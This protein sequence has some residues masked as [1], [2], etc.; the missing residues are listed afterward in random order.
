M[1]PGDLVEFKPG[2]HGIGAPNNYGIYLDRVRRKGEFYVVLWTVKGKLEMRREALTSRRLTARLDGE[3]D[4]ASLASRLQQLLKDLQKGKVREEQEF[5]GE[6]TDRELWRK[7][8][9]TGD[10]CSAETL[11]TLHFGQGA[12]KSQVEAV[13]KALERC[14]PGVGYFRR[15]PGKEERWLPIGVEQYKAAKREVEGFYVLRKKLVKEEQ[16]VEEGWPEPRTAY[17][18]VPPGEAGLTE[19]D[20]GRLGVAQRFMA[21]FV[22]HDRDTG[23]VTLGETGIHTIDGFSLFDFCRWLSA[24]WLGGALAGI[25]STFVEFLVEAGLWTEQEAL[26]AVAQR[27]V[28]QHPD[29]AWDTPEQVER[30]ANR[31][32]EAFPPAWLEPR[33]DLR[34]GHACF[35]IDPPDAKDFD[36]AV[37]VDFHADGSATLWVHIADVSHYVE[38]GALLDAHAR[39][40]ATSVYLPV[41]VLPMLPHRLSDDLC[42]LRA[43][44]DR[45]AM[46]AKLTYDGEGN[47]LREEFGES[48]IRVAENKHYGQ[49]DEAVR[50]G[51]E[52]FA[53]MEAFARRLGAKR[54]GLALETG[55]RKILFGPDGLVDPTLKSAT[56]ATRMIEVFMVAANE[57][58]ARKLTAEG[59]PLPYRC[60]PLPDRAAAERFNAQMRTME[61]PLAIQLPERADDEEGAEPE[62]PSLLE[63]LQKGGKLQLVSGG[64]KLEDEAPGAEPGEAL[65]P[66]LKGLAQ[67]GDEEQERWLQPFRDALAQVAALADEEVRDLV[68]LKLL[69]CMGRAFYTPRNLGHF[70]LGSTCYSHFTSPIRRYPDL[71]THRLLRWLLRGRPGE[72]PHT[73]EDLE[74]LSAHCSEQGSAAEELERGVVDVAMVFASRSEGLGA[75]RRGLVTGI[76]K[77]GVF[78]SFPGGLEGKLFVSDIPGGPYAVDEHDSMLFQGELER[79]VQEEELAELPWRELV[80]AE[81]EVVR[82]RLR[83]GDW[84]PVVVVGRDYVDGRVRVRLAGHLETRKGVDL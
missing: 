31:F 58:V 75:A 21:S 37:G 53:A 51:Q 12:G 46:T 42:S 32:P 23:E 82:V 38:M 64:F 45:L 39:G 43:G 47:L 24:D 41:K 18:G 9:G 76:T 15:A 55:E 79:P 16:V 1:R 81:G 71:V 30:E 28:L 69:G 72:R 8:S 48:V 50:Q 13:R 56:P 80:D 40:R 59:I 65:A 36:D 11:A 17:T 6:L 7:V 33:W 3:L 57:A 67:L 66:V 62:G 83:L 70:G 22:L 2:S 49:V 78:L 63:Q 27:H 19:E 68:Q 34:Q 54:R 4:E 73:D 35:T 10:A 60:H 74:E 61:L 52:P 26:Q 14:R 77:G 44:R 25:S 20:R 84:V 5:R 29:F